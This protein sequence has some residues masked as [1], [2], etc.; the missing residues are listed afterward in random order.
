MRIEGENDRLRFQFGSLSGHAVH[1]L[2][3]PD[4]NAVKVANG[5]DATGT[6]DRFS[7]RRNSFYDSHGT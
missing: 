6:L 2:A 5:D 3:M 7:E 1:Q 4:M